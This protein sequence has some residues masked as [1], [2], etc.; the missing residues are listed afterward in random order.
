MILLH[1]IE[2]LLYII[3]LLIWWHCDRN[4]CWQASFPIWTV[5]KLAESWLLTMKAILGFSCM[6]VCKNLS[7]LQTTSVWNLSFEAKCKAVQWLYNA[8]V[9]CT[10]YALLCTLMSMNTIQVGLWLNTTP[11]LSRGL[12]LKCIL[13]SWENFLFEVRLAKKAG[14]VLVISIHRRGIQAEVIMLWGT[15][16]LLFRNK[17]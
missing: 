6:I 3:E 16:T 14:N 12:Q 2:A 9:L 5:Q 7:L 13:F 10:E 1:F 15:C 11:K 4:L 17:R 8:P